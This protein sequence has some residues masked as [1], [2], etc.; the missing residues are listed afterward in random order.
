MNKS[1]SSGE[2]LSDM[3]KGGALNVMDKQK[4]NNPIN[5]K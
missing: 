2:K 3:Q 5:L 4:L 1:M